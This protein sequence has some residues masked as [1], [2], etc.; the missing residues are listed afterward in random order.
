MLLGAAGEMPAEARSRAAHVREVL[1]GYRS[2]S[3]ELAAPGEPRP[4]YAPGCR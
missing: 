4:E 1:S 3:E 2:G